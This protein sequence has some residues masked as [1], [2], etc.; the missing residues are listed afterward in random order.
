MNL[1]IPSIL[2]EKRLLSCLR[3][4][5]RSLATL[6]VTD[7]LCL[8]SNSFILSSNSHCLASLSLF[9]ADVNEIIWPLIYA[10]AQSHSIRGFLPGE[11]LVSRYILNSYEIK[12][13]NSLSLRRDVLSLHGLVVSLCPIAHF[14]KTGAWSEIVI[15]SISMSIILYKS[16]LGVKK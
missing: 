14:S 13:I 15:G 3:V 9:L 1:K 10:F 2:S 12:E 16:A 6:V 7:C 5:F 11:A 4:A 8:C